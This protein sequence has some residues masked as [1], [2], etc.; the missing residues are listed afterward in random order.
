VRSSINITTEN[1]DNTALLT[2]DNTLDTNTG[3]FAVPTAPKQKRTASIYDY[4]RTASF[5]DLING[6]D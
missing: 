3:E 1:T 6:A 2:E 5:D 4:S